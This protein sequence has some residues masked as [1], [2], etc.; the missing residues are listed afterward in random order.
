ML[1][2]K[3]LGFI[4]KITIVGFALYFLYHQLNS[5]SASEDFDLLYNAKTPDEAIKI[6]EKTHQM[7][8]KG[9]PNICLNY[10]RYRVD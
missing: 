6:I 3:T 4:L 7:Y 1:S 10:K 9:D 8:L 2:K 5:K